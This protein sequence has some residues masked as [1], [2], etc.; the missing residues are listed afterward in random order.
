NDCLKE[1]TNRRWRCNITDPYSEVIGCESIIHRHDHRAKMTSTDAHKTYHAVLNAMTLQTRSQITTTPNAVV[2]FSASSLSNYA[3]LTPMCRAC[4]TASRASRP[5]DNLAT[6]IYPHSRDVHT[7][8]LLQHEPNGSSDI[9]RL[10]G[11]RFE[12]DPA[13]STQVVEHFGAGRTR[14]ETAHLYP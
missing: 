7:I 6:G 1:N 11:W 9:L 14:C 2:R 3:L 13:L 12:I 5:S 4:I 8:R 10:D